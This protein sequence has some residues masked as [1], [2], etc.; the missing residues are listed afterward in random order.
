[1]TI[2]A[3]VISFSN[4]LTCVV[5]RINP[6]NILITLADGQNLLITSEAGPAAMRFTA[7]NNIDF[8]IASE[9]YLEP[10]Q[11]FIPLPDNMTYKRIRFADV[12][13]CL[14]DGI[15]VTYNNQTMKLDQMDIEKNETVYIVARGNNRYEFRIRSRGSIM[16]EIVTECRLIAGKLRVWF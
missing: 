14:S 3:L 7:S 15:S 1:M 9:K 5:F 11:G 8:L 6:G 16:D 2:A 13:V 4:L 10:T 12:T